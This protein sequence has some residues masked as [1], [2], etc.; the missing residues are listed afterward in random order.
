[1]K[2]MNYLKEI[3][4]EL[5][6]LRSGTALVFAGAAF[7]F[8]LICI[9]ACGNF[10]VYPLLLLP[11]HAPPAFFFFLVF[12]LLCALQGYV[13]GLLFC[14]CRTPKKYLAGVLFALFSF[15][16][17]LMWYIAFFKTFAF[18]FSLVLLLMALGMALLALK[19]SLPLAVIPS[20]LLILIM[21]FLLFELWITFSVILLN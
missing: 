17:V 20:L 18:L 4:R 19:E 8:S 10:Y 12:S 16:F 13:C 2:I 1:M 5:P 3:K 14:R 15:L 9:V 6:A 7:V 11:R 21:G